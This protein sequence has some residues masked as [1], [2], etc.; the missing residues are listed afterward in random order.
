MESRDRVER[1]LVPG[2]VGRHRHDGARPTSSRPS[3]PSGSRRPA[4]SRR[5]R[6]PSDTRSPG[7]T[8]RPSRRTASAF[9]VAWTDGAPSTA[10]DVRGG[11]VAADGTGLDALD[12]RDL[13]RRERAVPARRGVG[14]LQL[15]RCVARHA[16]GCRRRLRRARLGRAA[17]SWTARASS[18]DSFSS[19]EEN[20]AVA[21][22]PPGTLVVWDDFRSGFERDVYAA[23]VMPVDGGPRRDRPPAHP[24]DERRGH[25][26]VQPGRRV[27]RHELPGRM[28]RRS[29]RRRL[30]RLRRSRRRLRNDPGRHRLPD[31]G[32]GRRAVG[33][34]DRLERLRV[35]GGVAGPSGIAVRRVRGAHRRARDGARSGGHSD[36]DGVRRPARP[37]RRGERIAVPGGVG[38]LAR[39]EPGGIRSPRGC[40]RHRHRPERDRHL[41]RRGVDAGVP[42]RGVERLALPGGVAGPSGRMPPAT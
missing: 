21:A 18:I 24:R 17:P 40:V 30:R 15:P 2:R 36:L 27:G 33:A 3:T 34:V 31:L 7:R 20:P 16:V 22:G 23:R 39:H 42:R 12:D 14:R 13:R 26:P 5:P 38:R 6:P 35:P 41:E 19:G 1:F 32:G 10:Q 4:R 11:R 28:G 25:R 29:K 37:A 9:L 8:S